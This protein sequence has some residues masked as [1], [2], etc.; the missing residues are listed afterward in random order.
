MNIST[1]E[2]SLIIAI[3]SLLGSGVTLFL[4]QLRPPKIA[5]I[6]GSTIGVNHQ[7]TGFSLFMPITFTN[8]AH[9]PGLLNRCSLLVKKDGE[10]TSYYLEWTEFVK[11]DDVKKSYSRDDFAGPLQVQGRSSIS[12]FVC[13]RWRESEFNFTQGKYIVEI[14]A[15]VEN[16]DIVYIR[17]RH[18][19][20]LGE[21]EVGSL[22]GHKADKKT[23]IVWVSID[24]QIASNKL[25]TDHEIKKLLG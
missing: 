25:L 2:I 15:W 18:E 8:T 11:R 5:C 6:P 4:T 3:C 22:A 17:Q 9:Q 1:P 19:F 7:Q 13:F 10:P 16:K 20:F 21:K 24:K 14:I 23:A 12:K